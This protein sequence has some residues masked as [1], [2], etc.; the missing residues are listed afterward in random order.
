MT[1]YTVGTEV[2]YGGRRF[3][4]TSLSGQGPYSVRLLATTPDGPEV[5]V[6]RPADLTAIASYTTPRVDTPQQ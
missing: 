6:A 2:L 5:A 3:V 4:I 1:Q